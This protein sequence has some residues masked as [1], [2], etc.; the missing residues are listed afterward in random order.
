VFDLL[1]P[2]GIDSPGRPTLGALAD[3]VVR[4][5][6]D[7]TR[8]ADWVP[9][10]PTVLPRLLHSLRSEHTSPQELTEQLAHDPQLAA[11]VLREANESLHPLA[12]RLT[13]TEEA[14]KQLGLPGLRLLMARVAF[15][16]VVGNDAGPLM[17]RGAQRVWA[18]GE[19][20]ANAA[21]D[22]AS[23]RGVD[24]FEAYLSGL[25]LQIGL[26][27]ALRMSDRVA[28]LARPDANHLGPR[29]LPLGESDEPG[30]DLRAALL[31]TQA[32]A[33]L[34][35]RVAARWE[36]PPPVVGAVQ[37]LADPDTENQW[38]AHT[39]L[40]AAARQAAQLQVLASGGLLETPLAE[41]ALTLPD[42][43][44]LWL[45]RARPAPESHP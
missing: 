25:A 22:L 15:R 23:G 45:L 10:V 19:A 18:L 8:A 33:A 12:P 2:E 11:E 38:P 6:Q 35:H 20:C 40:L 24:P 27:V 7:T 9:R 37:G 43:A 13:Q 5:S 4:M 34:S 31:L 39:S 42:D 28:H 26:L 17:R 1:R 3:A 36:L 41:A 30:S 21:R 32:T 14:V 44:R 16:P 29:S